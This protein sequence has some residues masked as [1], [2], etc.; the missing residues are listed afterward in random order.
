MNE[1]GLDAELSCWKASVSDQVGHHFIPCI[2][3]KVNQIILL[4]K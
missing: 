2:M 1:K 3:H 4:V